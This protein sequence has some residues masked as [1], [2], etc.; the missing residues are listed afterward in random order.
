[1][2]RAITATVTR[3]VEVDDALPLTLQNGDRVML[4]Q[5]HPERP[6]YYWASDGGLCSGWVPKAVLS[7]SGSLG[8]ATSE[9]CSQ[10]LPV[11]AGDK[12]RVMWRG[13]GFDATWC[14][15]R[16]G[17]RGWVPND[18]LDVAATPGLEP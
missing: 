8:M 14:E 12:V 3:D 4:S 6:D 15:S 16:D 1:M 5:T 9:Y 10:E 7:I 18:A 11:K 13:Q 2:L 17:E